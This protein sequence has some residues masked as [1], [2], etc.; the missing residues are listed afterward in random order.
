[1]NARHFVFATLRTLAAAAL[2]LVP[3]RGRAELLHGT[4][5]DALTGEPVAGALVEVEGLERQAVTD[6]AGRY[7]IDV[8]E[9]ASPHTLLVDAGE[10]EPLRWV[11]QSA[12]HDSTL[13]VFNSLDSPDAGPTWGSPLQRDFQV[14]AVPVRI[15]DLPR[16]IT[17]LGV[18]VGPTLPATIR[19]G[20][21][22]SDTC[23]GHDVTRIDEVDFE[24][25][26]QGVLV[27]EIGVFRSIQGGPESSAAVFQ[28][29]A[30]AARS[31]A[32]WFYLRDPGA[33][34]HIDDTACNQRYDDARSEFVAAQV[35]VTAGM[36]M[37]AESDRT[38]LDKLE[39]AA[40]CGR[41][42]SRPEYQDALVP[43]E[44]GQNACVGSW[45]GH[46][47]CAAHEDNPAVPGSDR[48]LVRGICQW[49]AAERSMRGDSY[50]SI[51]EHYQPNLAVVTVGAAPA[52]GALV[53]YVRF[54]DVYTGAGAAGVA[55]TVD[56]GSSTTTNADG[57]YSFA[58]VTPGERAIS[59]SGGGIV[60]A[61]R[62]RLVEAGITNW[63][64]IAVA[65]DGT[66]L[67]DT[68]VA[69]VGVITDVGDDATTVADVAAEPDTTTDLPDTSTHDVVRDDVGV[70]PPDSGADAAVDGLT[71][72]VVDGGV[73]LF[74]RVGPQGLG[75]TGVACAASR[76][77]GARGG[78]GLVALAMVLSRRRKHGGR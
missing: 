21:R 42:G 36:I 74:D 31:Y 1:M 77:P 16:P 73:P 27:P 64:S 33:E 78:L 65:R 63:A 22:F 41:N 56:D 7:Q 29:F 71:D 40:S 44:T 60:A 66:P 35:A 52:T 18:T 76:A 20:R 39:Y 49:G 12:A 8:G 11:N 69:D 68:A 24:T 50:Q 4:V 57:Y 10:A 47:G 55:V 48:C 32:L 6:A 58:N 46:N 72:A 3:M 28:A 37:V 26:V 67:D 15:T 34:W 19:V 54:D 38:L 9:H 14:G 2:V 75:D 51:L 53:G 59:F 61:S 17:V 5:L 45:C 13:R 25:Y 70:A 30:V 43:D 23:S 62:T